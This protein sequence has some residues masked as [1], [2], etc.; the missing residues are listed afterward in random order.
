MERLLLNKERIGTIDE[1]TLEIVWKAIVNE[2]R[3][4]KFVG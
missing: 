3:G 1:Y 2:K 4:S